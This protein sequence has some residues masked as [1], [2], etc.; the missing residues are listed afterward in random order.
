LFDSFSDL[1]DVALVCV[2]GKKSYVRYEGEVDYDAFESVYTVSKKIKDTTS[3]AGGRA[4]SQRTF[5]L[6]GFQ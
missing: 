6:G 5:Y 2:K 1:E 3:L 4:L